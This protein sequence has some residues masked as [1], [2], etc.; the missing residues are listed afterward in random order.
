M[1]VQDQA[2]PAEKTQTSKPA[3]ETQHPATAPK[4]DDPTL[5]KRL[6][7]GLASVAD[8]R[9]AARRRL[10]RA[11]FDFIDGGAGHEVTLQANERAFA[12]YAFYPRVLTDVSHID[13]GTTVL[14]TRVDLPILL[15]PSGTQRLVNTAGETA[16]ARAAGRFHTIYVLTVGSSRTIEEVAAAGQG[17]TLWLQLYLWRDRDWAQR[18]L[19]RARASNF[20]ALCVTVDIKSP[21]G[22]KYRDMR[23][24]VARM[25]ESLSVST[26]LDSARHL[27]WL[28]HYMRGGP[29]RTVH[30]LEEGKGASVFRAS[31]ATW[32]R[33]DPGA[34]WEEIRWLRRIWH[35][36]LVVKGILTS[37]DAQLAFDSGADAVVCSNHGGRA[38]DGN[39]ATLHA[40]PRVVEVAERMGKE[41]YMDGGIRTGGDAV[42]A[43]ALG[44]R[45]CLIVRPFWWGLTLG[46]EAGVASILR[47]FKDE[48]TSTMT[49]LGRP[50]LSDLDE[51]CLEDLWRG[52]V[53]RHVSS[54]PIPPAS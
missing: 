54:A 18:L 7:G 15:G 25:P 17:A 24:G 36:P 22:P 28:S 35:G 30:I 33:M 21:G 38:L 31:K 37:E 51:S 40:L 11:I 19:D 16:V 45:A 1:T 5:G 2:G 49:L 3:V 6:Y 8:Y 20:E 4:E 53:D 41:V 10:P 50:R 46:G 32:R 9:E 34:N 27:R 48:L 12:R 13:L 47:M 26:M 14:G 52:A 42:K 44:A 43:I 39:P 29:I 23:N